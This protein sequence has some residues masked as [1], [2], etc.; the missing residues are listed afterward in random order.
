MIRPSRVLFLV[1]LW[2]LL[3]GRFSVANVASGIAVALAVTLV[4]PSTRGESHR[5]P[6]R[7]LANL[8]LF[9]NVGRQLITSNVALTREIV[10]RRSR[11]RTGVVACPLRT[12]DAW[13][14]AL[15]TNI[16]ALTPGTMPVRVE[17]DP[18]VIHVH[19]LH[20]D[21]PDAVRRMVAHLEALVVAAYGP[22]PAVGG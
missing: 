16:L 12:D 18:G 21:D 9:A 15:V 6:V 5:F 8:R 22:R 7:P 13:S 2:V 17:S 4:F 1:A 3:W 20:L 10:T 14:A 11:I 19:V